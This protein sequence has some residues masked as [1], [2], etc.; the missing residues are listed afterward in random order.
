[1]RSQRLAQGGLLYDV[2]GDVAIEVNASG[3]E[4]V[5]RLDGRHTRRDL[6]ETLAA[7]YLRSAEALRSDVDEFLR[8][9][10]ARSL[11][12]WSEPGS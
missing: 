11:L 5:Q 8:A 4:I 10:E 12:E 3:W 6:A 7:L 1:V 2:A 9:L